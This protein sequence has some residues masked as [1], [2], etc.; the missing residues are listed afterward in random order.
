M[1]MSIEA[2]RE[3]PSSLRAAVFLYNLNGRPLRPKWRCKKALCFATPPATP[4]G[5]VRRYLNAMPWDGLAS[6]L[7]QIADLG[8]MG[9]R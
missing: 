4:H 1:A 8:D 5:P 7:E 3:G 6:V 9:E 2:M